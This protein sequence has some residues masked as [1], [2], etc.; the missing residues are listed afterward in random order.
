[1]GPNVYKGVGAPLRKQPRQEHADQTEQGGAGDE[2]RRRVQCMLH[3]LLA[4]QRPATRQHDVLT[5]QPH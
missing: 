4:E 1:M 5:P 3:E 2:E